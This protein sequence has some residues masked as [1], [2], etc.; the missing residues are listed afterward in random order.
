[1]ARRLQ[2]FVLNR[3]VA[4]TLSVAAA[5]VLTAA[6]RPLFGGKAPL[7]FFTIAAILSASY[8]GLTAGLLVTALSVCIA[9]S[10]F[11]EHVLVMATPAWRSSPS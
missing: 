10:L 6:I 11:Q 9:L 4:S 2:R 8:G 3:Y 1:M 5:A 7:F